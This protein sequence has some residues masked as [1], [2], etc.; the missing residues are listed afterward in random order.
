MNPNFESEMSSQVNATVQEAVNVTARA[1]HEQHHE[2]VKGRLKQELEARGLQ[3]L[4]DNWLEELAGQIRE[5]Q[6]VIVTSD[7]EVYPE[8]YENS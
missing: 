6:V 1:H 3:D 2:D 4:D 8:D 5:S 7:D